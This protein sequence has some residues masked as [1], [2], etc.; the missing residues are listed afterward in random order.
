LIQPAPWVLQLP[1]FA[2]FA[3]RNFDD[4][5]H[6]VDGDD[7][8]DDQSD[9]FNLSAQIDWEL[10]NGTV[11]TS[12]TG[13]Q[14]W[15][16]GALISA[17]SLRNPVFELRQNQANEILSQEFRIVSPTGGSFDYV[18]GLYYILK[19]VHGITAWVLTEFSLCHPLL[20]L[21]A[22]LLAPF[23][24]VMKLSPTPI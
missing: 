11:I 16:T 15:E 22:P 21:F 13:Y 23:N 19:T 7:V 18:A 5:D 17:D 4:S 9:T 12:L 3:F 14:D 6:I 8:G 1:V 20:V 10:A 24:L 2:G